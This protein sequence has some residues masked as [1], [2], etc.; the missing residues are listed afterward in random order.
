MF[1]SVDD[2]QWKELVRLVGDL[3]PGDDT[4]DLW[5]KI[6]QICA[7]VAAIQADIMPESERDY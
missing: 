1:M 5:F 7:Q 4:A 2:R 3:E 6:G